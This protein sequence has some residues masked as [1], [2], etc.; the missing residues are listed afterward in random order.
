M[1]TSDDHLEWLSWLERE[2]RRVPLLATPA[3]MLTVRPNH[4]VVA[5]T[6]V[7]SKRYH[8]SCY[9]LRIQAATVMTFSPHIHLPNVAVHGYV[10]VTLETVAVDDVYIEPVRIE[11]VD[12]SPMHTNSHQ[13][14]NSTNMDPEIRP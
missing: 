5:V 7:K 11:G 6:I 1:F 10:S 14:I 12:R 2:E 3:S 13:S 8:V 4:N 9:W